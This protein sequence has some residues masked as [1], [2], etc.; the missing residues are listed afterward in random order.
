M[1]RPPSTS[2]LIITG[3]RDA[4]LARVLAGLERSETAPDEVVVVFMNQPTGAVPASTLRVVT[5]HVDEPGGLPL[6]AARN[7]AAALARGEVLI[8]LD[9][10]CLPATSAIGLLAHE[11]ARHPAALVMGTP[12]YLPP[13]WLDDDAEAL[14]PDQYLHEVSVDHAARRH[15]SPG[16]SHQ[17]PLVWTLVLALPASGMAALG[18][19]D[20]GFRGY[21]AEDTDFAFRARDAGWG[22]RFSAATV[23]HQPH[24]VVKPPLHHFRDILV[25]ARRFRDVHGGWPME[26]WLQQFT[27]LGLVDWDP[28]GARLEAL[29]EPTDAE[30]AAARD[31]TS[32]Y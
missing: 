27:D 8:F 2:V 30:L 11:V 32:A 6:A 7:R 18:G 31:E 12:R 29:R 1:T 14:P 3:G 24:G 15:L 9:V 13:G 21:G 20:E 23:F 25:N 5:G 19:F 28:E 10:D 26:G 17:W 4:H 16:P 22:L